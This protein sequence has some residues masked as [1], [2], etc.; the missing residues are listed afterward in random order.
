MKVL[1]TVLA[2]EIVAPIHVFA[3]ELHPRKAPLVDVTL[4]A[5]NAGD[6]KFRASAASD[7]RMVFNNFDLTLKPQYEGALPAHHFHRLIARVQHQ[8]ALTGEATM[9]VGGIR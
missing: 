7:F 8:G 4:Q 1:S 6:L 9:R 2:G 5:Q 3:T